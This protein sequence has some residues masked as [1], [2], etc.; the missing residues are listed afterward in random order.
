MLWVMRLMMSLTA[1]ADACGSY[2]DRSRIRAS[3]PVPHQQRPQIPPLTPGQKFA[4]RTDGHRRAQYFAWQ[5]G[6]AAV[7]PGEWQS[8]GSTCAHLSLGVGVYYRGIRTKSN[9]PRIPRKRNHF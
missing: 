1:A 4:T 6:R 2:V 7:L 3:P 8:Y 5:T 9:G